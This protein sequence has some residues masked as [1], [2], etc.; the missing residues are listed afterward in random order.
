R[1]LM[2][3]LNIESLPGTTAPPPQ[4]T[5]KKKWL[6]R[7]WEG[8]EANALKSIAGGV[9]LC[10]ILAATTIRDSVERQVQ[11]FFDSSVA[12]LLQAKESE[13][14][15]AFTTQ[16][17]EIYSSNDFKIAATKAI[18]EDDAEQ[19]K[20]GAITS[21]TIILTPNTRAQAIYVYLPSGTNGVLWVKIDWPYFK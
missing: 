13:F 3:E 2:T 12:R 11:G 16:L 6:E 5:K 1:T 15:K 19:Q 4:D 8:I 10:L 18:R 17:S 21:G 7:I 9:V 20:V 14:H